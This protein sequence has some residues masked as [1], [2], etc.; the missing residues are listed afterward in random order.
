MSFLGASALSF[1]GASTASFF[2]ALG[3]AGLRLGFAAGFSA[4]VSGLSAVATGASL[5]VAGFT[6]A[7]FLAA[8]DA[9]LGSAL[10]ALA[11]AC[12]AVSVSLAEAAVA[13]LSSI[14]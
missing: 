4:A 5:V 13:V 11:G 1:L 7:E 6:S 3:L 9:L 8:A 14:S 2:G 10:F 12:V